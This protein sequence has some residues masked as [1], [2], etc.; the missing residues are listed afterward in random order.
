MQGF[1]S[2]LLTKNVAVGGDVTSSALSAYTAG[3]NRQHHMEASSNDQH[4]VRGSSDTSKAGISRDNVGSR[5]SAQGGDD[6]G[7]STP[8][9]EAADDN[10][11]LSS[12]IVDPHKRPRDSHERV[13]EHEAKKPHFERVSEETV[14]DELAQSS[15][16][17][18]ATTV[19][20]AIPKADTV[21][22]ARLRYL[23]RKNKGPSN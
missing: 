2:N 17:L 1:Y 6:S 3:S 9:R 7:D 10:S 21:S 23:E 18:S 4:E 15:T 19:S 20:S 16:T 12:R 13:S 8:E 22:A 5:L 11:G 14:S